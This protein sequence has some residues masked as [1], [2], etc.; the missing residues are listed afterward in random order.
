MLTKPQVN[1]LSKIQKACIRIAHKRPPRADCAEL[2]HHS[3]LS[4]FQ[5][6]IELESVKYGYKL[7]HGLIPGPIKD[8]MH[9]NGGHKTH[10]YNTRNKS[11]LNIQK[12]HSTQFNR[13]FLCQST[14]NYS[15]LPESLKAAK[16][17]ISFTKQAKTHIL[18]QQH[19]N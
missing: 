7:S 10:R 16:T 12:L 18:A 14:V 4:T 17:T 13:S 5:Q 3:K 8:I 11:N 1:D 19:I 15:K 2:L 9:K 6:L